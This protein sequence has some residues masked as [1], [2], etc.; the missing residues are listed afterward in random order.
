MGSVSN[1]RPSR[2]SAPNNLPPVDV[3]GV[4]TLDQVRLQPRKQNEYVDTPRSPIFSS[5]KSSSQCGG[6]SKPLVGNLAPRERV[7]LPNRTPTTQSIIRTQPIST[8]PPL[9]K[10]LPLEVT[11]QDDAIICSKCGKCRCGAC[12]KDR[13]LPSK[14]LCGDK[15]NVSPETV[16]EYATCLCCVKGMFYHCSKDDQDA[17]FECVS[18]PCAGCSRPH[19]CKRW[20]CILA[21]SI[22]LPCMCLYPPAKLALMCCTSCYNKCRKKGCQCK[23][24]S[25]QK[26]KTSKFDSQY[27]GLLIESDR[28]SSSVS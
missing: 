18:D 5:G 27:R 17:E 15:F 4:I 7:I 12:T 14:W 16:V 22:C 20:T 6:G 9:K 23:S 13:E 2:Y 24:N 8:S 1:M 25:Q 11:Q 28:E 26:H 10:D 21:M 19:C 3:A